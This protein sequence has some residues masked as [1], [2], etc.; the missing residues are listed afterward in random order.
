LIPSHFGISDLPRFHYTSAL[1]RRTRQDVLDEDIVL[2]ENARMLTTSDYVNYVGAAGTL[3]FGFLSLVQARDHRAL[4]TALRA[5]NQ[6]LYNN[7]WRMGGNAEQAL[8]AN[9]L[10]DARLQSKGVADMSQTARHFVVAFAREHT[11]NVPFHDPAW[12]P[13]PLP[14]RRSLL[15]R[16]ISD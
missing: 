12:E 14:E 3:F 16:I 4:L 9:S 2:L 6:G 7:I 10:E 1:R 8:K 11:K 5:Y 13:K 15:K